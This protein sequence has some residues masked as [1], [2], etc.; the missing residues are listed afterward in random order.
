M[1]AVIVAAGRGKRLMP[2]TADRPKPLI[3]VQGTALLDYLLRGLRWSGITDV[4]IVIRYLGE[5]IEEA[6]GDGS[7][8]GMHIEYAHQTGLNGTGSALL[9]VEG[10][11]GDDPFLLMWG[12][13]LSDPDNYRRIQE[14]YAKHPC[15]LLSDLNWLDDPSTGA[16]VTIDDT[17]ILAIQEKPEPGS[18][19]SHWNQAGLFICRKK[20][21]Q[22]MRDSGVSPRGEIEFTGGVQVLIDHGD[23]VR[24]MRHDG[25]WSDVGTIELLNRLN[26]DPRVPSL[27]R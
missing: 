20:I 3:P 6:Y 9:A 13:V 7:S 16:S 27:L 25:F 1:K 23:E 14:L 26:A 5:K 18:A 11:V 10:L 2:L 12:D 15:E 24:Y 19:P 22:A 17:H 8:M 21:F 4:V